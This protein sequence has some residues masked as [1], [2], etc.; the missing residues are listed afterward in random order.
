M[1]ATGGEVGQSEQQSNQPPTAVVPDELKLK[2]FLV[3]V[4]FC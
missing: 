4:R 3:S 2:A 1:A